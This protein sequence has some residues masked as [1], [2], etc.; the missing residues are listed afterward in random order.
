ML[1]STSYCSA[2]L[3]RFLPLVGIAVAID[4]PEAIHPGLVER[5]LSDAFLVAQDALIERI[6]RVRHH[7]DRAETRVDAGDAAFD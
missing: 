7:H 6:T 2:P 5:R 1:R 4:R 3:R